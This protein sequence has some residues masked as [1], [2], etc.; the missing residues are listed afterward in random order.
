M[1]L[2][3]Y[4]LPFLYTSRKCKHDLFWKTKIKL[5]KEAKERIIAR[6]LAKNN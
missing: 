3:P 6:R 1:T 4:L 2:L 5:I